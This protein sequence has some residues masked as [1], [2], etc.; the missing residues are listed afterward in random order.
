MQA[1]L[2]AMILT[3]AGALEEAQARKPPPPAPMLPPPIMV[4]PPVP[5]PYPRVGVPAPPPRP[6]PPQRAR[7]NLNSYFSMDDYPA[8]AIRAYHEGTTAFRLL[9]GPDGRVAECAVTGSSGSAPLDEATC[10]I[11]RSRARYTPA[12]NAE[13][14][15]VN[16][17]DSG[18][19]TWRLPGSY[20]RAGLAMAYRPTRLLNAEAT[21]PT[22]ADLPPA[23]TPPPDP[24]RRSG[25]RL[26][27]GQQGRVVACDIQMTSGSPAL[28]A[29]ACQ[30]YFARA[31]Y[32]P[33][34]NQGGF[35]VCDVTWDLVEWAPLLAGRTG[36]PPRTR[37][38]RVR[39]TRPLLEQLNGRLCP[40]WVR[41]RAGESLVD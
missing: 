17:A 12:R 38:P 8:A 9:I 14:S 27:V 10:R 3:G 30:L 25:L 16:G 15:P 5:A 18:R 31:R 24:N 22:L 32:E 36:P 33:G 1:L 19:V 2:I 40:G 11:L 28:D 13:G 29:A 34:R 37:A 20:D 23:V 7:A 4:V 35:A 39:A 21:H 41:P 26:V 6:L